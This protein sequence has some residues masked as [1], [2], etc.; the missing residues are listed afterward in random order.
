MKDGLFVAEVAHSV[1]KP[2]QD[3]FKLSNCVL[4]FFVEGVNDSGSVLFINF[5]LQ[6]FKPLL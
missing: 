5:F 4:I 3:S 6:K 1:N 2:L